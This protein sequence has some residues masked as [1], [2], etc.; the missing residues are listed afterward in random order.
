MLE[1]AQISRG[2]AKIPNEEP[3]DDIASV[4]ISL[5]IGTR[6]PSLLCDILNAWRFGDI[7]AR[8]NASQA[9]ILPRPATIR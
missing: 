4:S 2:I 8:N 3:P 5:I 1:I 6:K 9:Y 7:P